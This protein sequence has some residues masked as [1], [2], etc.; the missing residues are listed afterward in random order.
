MA[1]SDHFPA[2][3][4]TQH[5]ALGILKAC[6]QEHLC[7]EWSP[8][9]QNQEQ[10]ENFLS[11]VLQLNEQ[12]PGGLS[13]Y[14]QNAQT[15]LASSKAGENP[16]EGFT[17]K[18]PK[19]KVLSPEQEEFAKME[20]IGI[21]ALG[22]TG[23]VLVAGGLGERLGYGGIKIALPSE[24]VTGK[25][26][27]QLYIENILAYQARARKSSGN[28]ELK[29]PLAIMTS[30]DTHQLTVDLLNQ[31]DNFGMEADQL[32]IMKQ[33]KVP[34]LI[35][36]QGHFVTL[37]DHPY[38]IETKPH[39]HGDVHVLLHQTGTA[40]KWLDQGIQWLLFFQDTNGIVF[41][42][43]P[44]TLGVSQ[45]EQLEV[46]SI[47][48]PRRAGEAAG[49]IVKLEK[50]NGDNITINVEYNQLDP[51]LRSTVNPEGDAADETGYS[52][53]PGNI[54]ILAFALAPYLK[55]LD[56][57]GG[58]IPEFVNPKYADS[59]KD[60]FKKPTRLECMMQDYPK[61][62]SPEAKVGFTSFPREFCF[63][64]VKNNLV[65][66]AAKSTASMP[67][68]SASSGEMDTYQVFRQKAT[69]AG[70][71]IEHAEKVDMAGISLT[72]GPKVVFAN[73]FACT[74]SE[75]KSKFKNVSLSANSTLVI[76]GEG[77]DIDGL[78]LDGKLVIQAINEAKVLIKNLKVSNQGDQ[79]VPLKGD[80]PEYLKI[81]GYRI[82]EIE[83]RRIEVS[84]GQHVVEN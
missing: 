61:L 44:A 42:A 70:A 75:L 3:T 55:N 29:L 19:G 51:L 16:Y 40:Q 1:L 15:L 48:V 83:C 50:A 12:Y 79:I 24:T 26:F 64:A 13:Q 43:I 27:I 11:Q 72:P 60:S 21:Q 31:H 39:G 69:L 4:P 58:M 35:N 67:A 34:S 77:V 36:N 45:S 54:N 78:T 37:G 84:E 25:T 30:G 2:P 7:S 18:V 59:S 53:Y 41:N 6:D 66:A 14:C 10:K 81:R 32:T 46:N 80:E 47:T 63:S 49:G 57:S 22:Q 17:P 38:E 65:D 33:E 28:P 68:E 5:S 73:S 20:D 9:G 71:K 82:D 56:Q 52:P 74:L 76:E 23:F 62:L 8:V